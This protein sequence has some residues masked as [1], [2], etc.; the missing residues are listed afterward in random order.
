M[1]IN[2]ILSADQFTTEGTGMDLLGSS[3]RNSAASYDFYAGKDVFKAFVLR[4]VT[5]G[6]EM[7][8]EEMSVVLGSDHTIETGNAPFTIYVVRIDDE[9]SPHS[10]LPM[11]CNIKTVEEAEMDP[12]WALINEHTWIT[13]EEDLNPG[14]LIL[15]KLEKNGR[16]FNLRRGTYMGKLGND[17]ALL[18][19]SQDICVKPSAAFKKK[20]KPPAKAPAAPAKASPAPLSSIAAPSLTQSENVAN[21]AAAFDMR[22]QITTTGRPQHT[23]LGSLHPDFLPYVKAFLYRCDEEGIK[24]RI[25][26]TYRSVEEQKDL[27]SGDDDTGLVA[28]KGLSHHNFG[29]GFD[30]NPTMPAPPPPLVGEEKTILRKGTDLK[31]WEDNAQ[32]VIDIIEKDLGLQWG[33][34]FKNF[35]PTHFDMGNIA[36]GGRKLAAAA[37]KQGLTEDQYATVSLA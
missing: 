33:G 36:G 28:S 24:I 16:S 31:H 3:V 7:S 19:V 37:K 25:N 23:A 21:W 10:F 35:D 8:A 18:N 20:K 30:F 17:P 12:N 9:N 14:D 13:S 6:K 15:I 27:A 4:K 1:S 29:M 32:L 5:T 34:R 11:P 22:P 2:D 26:S